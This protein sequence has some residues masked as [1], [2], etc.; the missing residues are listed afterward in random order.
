LGCDLPYAQPIR[1]K[2]GHPAAIEDAFRAMRCKILPRPAHHCLPDLSSDGVLEV[3]R[4]SGLRPFPNELALK[5]CRGSQHV[6]KETRSWIAIICIEPL[7]GCDKPHTMG[8]Q[9]PEIG[10]AI[11]QRPSKAVQLPAK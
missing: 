4:T 11:K 2:L 1:S 7:R 5:L 6:K 8:I 3:P 9:L 10:Q